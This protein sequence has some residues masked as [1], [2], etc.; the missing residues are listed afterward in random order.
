M[1]LSKLKWP[2]LVVVVVGI[3]FLFTNPGVNYLHNKFTQ[4]PDDP[5][6]AEA[7]EAALSKL[8]GFCMKTFR[9][10]KAEA[11]FQDALQLYPQGK[12]SLYNYYRLVKIKEKLG[13]YP[14]AVN[15]LADLIAQNAHAQ[16]DRVPE[17]ANLDLRR[18]KLLE[19]HSLGEIGRD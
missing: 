17:R 4:P 14:E 9:Y 16:D 1:D 12:N 5:K 2:I 13:K 6:K 15:I 11:V 8:G 19:T 10:K 7:N 18:N 3:G